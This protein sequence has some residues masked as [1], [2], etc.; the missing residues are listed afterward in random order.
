MGLNWQPIEFQNGEALLLDSENSLK[1]ITE[2]LKG[3]YQI[4][5]ELDFKTPSYK[6][7]KFLKD[8][9]LE[10]IKSY[11]HL[12]TVN[13]GLNP[14][15]CLWLTTLEGSHCCLYV[16][17]IT[18]QIIWSKHRL[19]PELFSGTLFE[20]EMIGNKFVIWDLLLKDGRPVQSDWTLSHRIEVIR[21]MMTQDYVSDPVIENLRLELRPY[22]EY[23]KIKS[24]IRDHLLVGEDKHLVK[25]ITFIPIEKSTKCYSVLF[26]GNHQIKPQ[27]T[28]LDLNPTEIQTGPMIHPNEEN[29]FQQ[30]FW[31]SSLG[32]GDG[33]ADNY[34]QYLEKEDG[35]LI[36]IGLVIIP[37]LEQS[38]AVAKIFREHKGIQ[39]NGIKHLLKFECRYLKRFRK[40][41]PVRLIN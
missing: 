16:N 19:A 36:R 21:C 20:G 13:Y 28:N 1:L 37:E 15:W 8:D 33:Q 22:V 6:Y 41:K 14:V 10:M 26:D 17:L 34:Y 30:Q 27:V 31:L 18:N 32:K 2:Q 25:G 35:S 4:N 23:S 3:K 5:T 9:D 38:L 29:Q 11:R 39:K 12:V 7:F 24:F 40:W